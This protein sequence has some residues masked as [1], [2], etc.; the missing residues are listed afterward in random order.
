MF[1][2]APDSVFLKFTEWTL[3]I[4]DNQGSVNHMKTYFEIMKLMRK[5]MGHK[6]TN[7]NLD[8]KV[9]LLLIILVMH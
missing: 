6:K 1:I 8:G 5:D 3:E 2:Y 4:E 7:I 9:S